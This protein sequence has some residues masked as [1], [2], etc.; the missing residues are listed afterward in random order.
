[1]YFLIWFRYVLDAFNLA[2]G[3]FSIKLNVI[4][5]LVQSKTFSEKDYCTFSKI[6]IYMRHTEWL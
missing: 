4:Q 3:S 1:M 5:K 2:N 6:C